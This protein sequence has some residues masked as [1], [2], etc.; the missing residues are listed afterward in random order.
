MLHDMISI[1]LAL[2]TIIALLTLAFQ[3]VRREGVGPRWAP[4]LR[5]AIWA[6][7]W[8]IYWPLQH[9]LT[10]TFRIVT[11]HGHQG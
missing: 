6:V 9:G 3:I 10:E 8:P 2:Y 7:A 1:L 5:W 11:G 4:P